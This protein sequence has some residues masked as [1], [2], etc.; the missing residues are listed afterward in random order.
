MPGTKYGSTVAIFAPRG[1]DAMVARDLLDQNG[2]DRRVISATSDL[3][4][5]IEEHVGVVLMTEEAIDDR[6]L[7]AIGVTLDAQTAWSDIP[8]VVLT[9]ARR[10]KRSQAQEERIN[11]F[12]NVVLL[13]RPLHGEDLVRAVRSALKARQRQF[14]AR[15]RME[16]LREQDEKLRVSERKFHAIANSI[17]QMIWSTR[18]DGFHDYF[19]DRWYEYTGVPPGST[20]G[21]AWSEVFHPDDQERTQAIWRLSLATGEPYEIEYRLRHRSGE[22]RWVLGKA[23]AVRD[24]D[25]RITRWYGTCTD[26]H[27]QVKI[28]E[29]LAASREILERAVAERTQELADLYRKTPVALHSLDRD[30]RIV[31][32]SDRWL[33]FMG[34]DR[35][36]EVIGRPIVE[37]IAPEFLAQ[38]TVAPGDLL[39]ADGVVSDL[40]YTCV[41]RSGERAD[42]LVSARVTRSP[43]GQL[44]RIMASVVDVTQR[45]QA[46]AARDTAEAALRQSQKLETI[47]QLTGGVAH[48][49]NNLLMAIRSSLELLERRIPA[50]DERARS[51][52][53]NALKGAERGASLTQRML[54][55]ARKQEL[56][57]RPV[58]IAALLPGMRDLLERSL[59]PQIDI[60]L[61]IAPQVSDA[62]VDANQLEMAILNL[63]VNARDAMDGVG[64][65]AI[66]VDDVDVAD[67][68]D[69]D[70][71]RYVRIRMD[72]E[73]PG[74]DEATIARA[75]EPFFTTK[76]V[77]RGTGL[78]LSMVHG[79]ASQSGGGFRLTSL[80]DKGTTAEIFL[81]VSAQPSQQVAIAV[82]ANPDL[83]EGRTSLVILAVDDDALVLFGTS[84]LL[85]DLGHEVIEAGSGASALDALATRHDID[86]VITDQ[87]MPNMTG[88]DL[89]RQIH[90]TSPH[91]PVVLASGYAEM[92]EG[93]KD[94]IIARLEKPFS[95][96]ELSDT[97]RMV[98]QM[99][100]APGG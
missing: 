59:G 92:P 49:F 18:P 16:E 7:R 40:P 4:A 2:I 87:A 70:P 22:F 12:G 60:A 88:V 83:N 23:Q 94:H 31:S 24:E 99:I 53:E 77:G 80:L 89:A 82:D 6:D 48:D 98:R 3:V 78:G 67:A 72:D 41:K 76:G 35:A 43:D 25:G 93:A 84:A 46:E 97:I 14:E 63:A 64:R 42:V 68:A 9:T 90:E 58:D 33:A 36:D 75:A 37:F 65:L 95:D 51:Y 61:D 52:L 56:D 21:E 1:R 32:V 57:P 55:F 29:E 66:A 62:L 44:D 26:I 85:E 54:A 100:H 71:G 86:L 20:E 50:S 11:A 74:M 15:A 45:K 13:T 81:P 17:D 39:G 91:L 38:P 73:G 27:E 10:G 19:N 30:K 28:R 79:L 47:G 34:Y 96:K 5:L 69:L 8:F